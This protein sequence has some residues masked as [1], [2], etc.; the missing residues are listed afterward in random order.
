MAK[1][2]V[3]LHPEIKRCLGYEANDDDREVLKHF[4]ALSA[5]VCKPCWELRYCPYGPLVEQSPLLPPTRDSAIEH[6]EYLKESLKTGK[7]ADGSS[8]DPK[9]RKWFKREVETF[10][11][12]KY[13]ESI[14]SVIAEMQ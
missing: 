5:R 1:S 7:L 3:P 11:P 6:Q 2:T 8:L 10:N 9:R 12:K 13:P 14:P 4:K